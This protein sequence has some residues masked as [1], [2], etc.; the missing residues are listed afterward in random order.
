M[1]KVL[2]STAY[3]PR[4]AYAVNGY[5]RALE[6]AAK[7]A[8]RQAKNPPFPIVILNEEGQVVQTIHG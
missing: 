6:W 1:Y 7:L 2:Y 3:G 4:A 5:Y 8:V